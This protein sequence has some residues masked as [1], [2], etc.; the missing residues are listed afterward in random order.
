[1][2]R[3]PSPRIMQAHRA[4]P[5]PSSELL[6][7][8]TAAELACWRGWGRAPGSAGRKV[9]ENSYPPVGSDSVAALP[10]GVALKARWKLRASPSP[11]VGLTAIEVHRGAQRDRLIGARMRHGCG[12]RDYRDA[13]HRRGQPP[14]PGAERRGDLQAQRAR[15]RLREGYLHGKE[16]IPGHR[17]PLRAIVMHC[18]QISDDGTLGIHALQLDARR[19]HGMVRAGGD[20][21]DHGEPGDLV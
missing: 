3:S 5:P 10:P 7:A 9:L 1:R 2:G 19:D 20:P 11:S 4:T 13:S 6:A 8:G 12:I 21:A 18:P 14:W 16:P 17:I 15:G